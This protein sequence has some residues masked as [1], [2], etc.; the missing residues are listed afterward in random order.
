MQF[1]YNF[2]FLINLSNIHGTVILRDLYL[3]ISAENKVASLI[4]FIEFKIQAIQKCPQDKY[5][6]DQRNKN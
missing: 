4:K 5:R 2:Y 6:D 1:I 3:I